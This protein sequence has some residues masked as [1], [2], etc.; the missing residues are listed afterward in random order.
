MGLLVGLDPTGL[1]PRIE[2]EFDNLLAALQTW[3]G[4]QEGLNEV[5]KGAPNV[6]TGAILIWSTSTAPSGYLLCDGAAVEQSTYPDL[7]AV[8][9]TTY[10]V[11]NGTTQFNVPDLRQKF[12][13]GKAAS[14]TGSTFAGTGGAIDHTHT[15]P[16]HTHTGPSHTH[17]SSGLSVSGTTGAGSTHSHAPGITTRDVA[18]G[19]GETVIA[20]ISIGNESAHTHDA[21][22]LDV[23]GSTDAEGTG[24]TGSAGT[25]ATGT[26]NPPFMAL[27]YVIK[28]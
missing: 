24:A 15:G 28:T 21:G 6:P 11:G 4:K 27:S 17:G 14:G 26:G 20:S 25:G 16:S 23:G 3:V 8:V 22:S 9:G 18:A 19:A 7:F 5:L 12:I 2:A 10:G 1:P 13:I